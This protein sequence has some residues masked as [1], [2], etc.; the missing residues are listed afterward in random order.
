MAITHPLLLVGDPS[1]KHRPPVINPAA[2]PEVGSERP[3]GPALFLTATW[4]EELD[5][6]VE[7]G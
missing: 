3:S 1:L 5:L 7:W 6:H 2:Y 4:D